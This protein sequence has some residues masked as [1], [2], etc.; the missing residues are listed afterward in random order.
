MINIFLLS[1]QTPKQSTLFSFQIY[2]TRIEKNLLCQCNILLFSSVF[3]CF[4][5][6]SAWFRSHYGFLKLIQ[7]D[8]RKEEEILNFESF[9]LPSE[10]C[11]LLL[12]R[13]R[14]FLIR[15]IPVNLITFFPLGKT[16]I[17]I[18]IFN[19][20]IFPLEKTWIRIRIHPKAWTWIHLKRRMRN[21]DTKILPCAHICHHP[22]MFRQCCGSGAGS[23]GSK[24]FWAIRIRFYEIRILLSFRKNSKKSLDS[25]SFVTSLWLFIFEERCKC[26]IKK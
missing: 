4:V 3:P 9:I 20:L 19:Y 22:E 23:V 17:R 7:M 2:K 26:S 14:A 10:N 21:A 12:E 16:W 18:R 15:K 25:Y 1:F 5:S 13:W 11:R 24:Y 6:V 8:S